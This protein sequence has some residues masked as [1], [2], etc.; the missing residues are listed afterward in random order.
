VTA[1]LRDR[2]Y[3]VFL[4]SSMLAWVVYVGYESALPVA[5][6]TAYDVAPR[7]WGLLLA[8]NPLLVALLQ[9]RLTSA[10]ARASASAKLAVAIPIMGLSFLA[11]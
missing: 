6:T 7:T 9:L 4:V 2:P 1:A 5:A 10:V 3:L 8:L 11:F